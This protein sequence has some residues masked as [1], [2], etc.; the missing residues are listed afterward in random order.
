MQTQ[1]LQAHSHPGVNIDGSAFQVAAFTATGL[2]FAASAVHG[3]RAGTSNLSV[4]PSTGTETRP[5]N[6]AYSPRIHA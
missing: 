2:A 3:F 6:T 4:N 1:K 5:M